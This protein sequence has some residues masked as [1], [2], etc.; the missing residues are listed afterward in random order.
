[1]RG[2]YFS[3]AHANPRNLVYRYATPWMNKPASIVGDP[4]S[5]ASATESPLFPSQLLAGVD[6][7]PPIQEEEQRSSRRKAAFQALL[8]PLSWLKCSLFA[9]GKIV[10]ILRDRS[11]GGCFSVFYTFFFYLLFFFCRINLPGERYKLRVQKFNCD[12]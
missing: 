8:L 1:M 5:L 6:T 3:I 11:E 7:T 12:A 9:D 10:S 4:L 2:T